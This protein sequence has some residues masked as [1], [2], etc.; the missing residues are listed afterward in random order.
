[1][2]EE[3]KPK[4]RT[5][6]KTRRPFED[7]ITQKRK[8]IKRLTDTLTKKSASNTIEDTAEQIAQAAKELKRWQG[9]QRKLEIV[10]EL[11]ALRD[12]NTIRI[13][14]DKLP[15]LEELDRLQKDT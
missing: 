10:G 15:I 7:V 6:R 11:L 3:K 2:A 9:Y 5:P 4:G 13:P 14:P 1:M 8:E 12:G